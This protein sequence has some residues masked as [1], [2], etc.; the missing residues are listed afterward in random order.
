[1][2]RDPRHYE[3]LPRQVYPRRLEETRKLLLEH[4]PGAK[5]FI[6]GLVKTKGVNA[7]YHLHRVLELL[8][9]HP[10]ERVAEAIARAI[11]Y[12]VFDSRAVRNI[13]SQKVGPGE[14]EALPPPPAPQQHRLN[15]VQVAVRPLAKY[16][17]VY[18]G[19]DNA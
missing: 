16:E 19:G 11:S 1:M 10:W 15:L 5:E 9:L 6:A 7:R 2:I 12:G 8:E 14:E 4:F 3:G 13:C 18:G 17:A